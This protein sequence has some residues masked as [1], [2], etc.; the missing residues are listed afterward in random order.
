MSHFYGSLEN[1]RGKAT[2]TGNKQNGLTGH[3]RGWD[4]GGRI[5]VYVDEYGRDVVGFILTGGSNKNKIT[6]NNTGDFEI[7]FALNPDGT[8]EKL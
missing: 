8:V 1:H 7:R 2:R 3:I 6:V 5:D 4:I